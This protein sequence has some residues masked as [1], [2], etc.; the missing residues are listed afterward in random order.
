MMYNKTSSSINVNSSTA[1]Y[2]NNNIGLI[3]RAWCLF[4]K[5]MTSKRTLLSFRDINI[6]VMLTIQSAEEWYLVL[7]TEKA[8]TLIFATS[9]FNY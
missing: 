6:P 9:A 5:M 7:L 1:T 8:P 2:I 4:T 3:Q